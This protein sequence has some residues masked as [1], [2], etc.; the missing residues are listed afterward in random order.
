[1]F[2]LGSYYVKVKGLLGIVSKEVDPVCFLEKYAQESGVMLAANGEERKVLNEAVQV[3]SLASDQAM[4]SGK[5]PEFVARAV[6]CLLAEVHTKAPFSKNVERHTQKKHEQKTIRDRYAEMRSMLVK[7]APEVPFLSGVTEKNIMTHIPDILGFF[8]VLKARQTLN[9][10]GG[11]EGGGDQEG[12]TVEGKPDILSLFSPITV[13]TPYTPHTPCTPHTPRTPG[14]SDLLWKEEEDNKN[15]DEKHENSKDFVK[16]AVKVMSAR[17]ELLQRKRALPIGPSAFH[18]N[19]LKQQDWEVKVEKAEK[20]LNGLLDGVSLNA[21]EDDY[22]PLGEEDLVIQRLMLGGRTGKELRQ[23]V[24]MSV[25]EMEEQCEADGRQ[26][27]EEKKMKRRK[28]DSVEVTADDMS[29]D[30]VAQYVKTHEE[31]DARRKWDELVQQHLE[32]TKESQ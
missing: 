22:G 24:P 6:L 16:P 5:N 28:L 31:V 11:G 32:K 20:Y 2:T 17:Q 30:E 1:M 3:L 7:L 13:S 26:E 25:S 21:F 10:S 9:V 12:K 19:V 18:R 29:D 15:D 27:Q 14:S 8:W 4:I 23:G